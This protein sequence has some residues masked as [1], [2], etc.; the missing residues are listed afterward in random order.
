[1]KMLSHHRLDCHA[2]FLMLP[3]GEWSRRGDL[4]RLTPGGRF[5]QAR[6]G[7]PIPTANLYAELNGLGSGGTR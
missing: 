6:T 2:D 4:R 7:W 3:L 5:V 1:M